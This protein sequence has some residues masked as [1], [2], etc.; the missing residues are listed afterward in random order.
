VPLSPLVTQVGALVHSVDATALPVDAAAWHAR[1]VE[2]FLASADQRIVVLAFGST[3]V[4]TPP[5][6]D[7]LVDA[8]V[9]LLRRRA[10]VRVIVAASWRAAEFHRSIERHCG[11]AEQA[12]AA[13]LCDRRL[14]LAKCIV[15][16]AVVAQPSVAAVGSHCGW[17]SLAEAL[18][19]GKP[20]LAYPFAF[21]QADNA[22]RAVEWGGAAHRSAHRRRGDSW[23]RTRAADRQRVVCQRGAALA[24]RVAVCR[25]HRARRGRDR[26][27]GARRPRASAAQSQRIVCRRHRIGDCRV[28]LV[29]VVAR[30]RL[31][32]RHCCRRKAKR[33]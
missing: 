14:L 12:D 32:W 27:R 25:R 18:Y 22:Q 17:G 5:F 23:R 29:S 3:A 9:A 4:P 11:A 31:A 10:D 24:A 20:V 7:V 26:E 2:P 28:L 33:D 6:V 30:V 16:R 8:S 1:L 13:L 21:D 15:Q 19:Y